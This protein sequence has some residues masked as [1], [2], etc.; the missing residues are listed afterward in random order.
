MS[1]IE[2]YKDRYKHYFLDRSFEVREFKA[3][4]LSRNFNIPACRDEKEVQSLEV[5]ASEYLLAVAGRKE[6]QRIV[7]P[8]Y[9]IAG[10][11]CEGLL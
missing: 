11:C 3:R 8:S 6:A 9:I 5:G 10:I 1:L 7:T 4:S 2:H